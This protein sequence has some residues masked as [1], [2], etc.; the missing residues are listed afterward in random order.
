ME[1]V[2]NMALKFEP[3][4]DLVNAYLNRPSPGQIASEG[5][6]QAL[7]SYVHQKVYE[8]QLRTQATGELGNLFKAGGPYLVGKIGGQTARIAGLDP[9]VFNEPTTPSAVP[10]PSSPIPTAGVSSSPSVS[11]I[12]Q[13]HA[14]ATGWNPTGIPLDQLSQMGDYGKEQMQNY[15]TMGD[16]AMQPVEMKNKE[17]S[18]RAANARFATPAQ[19]AAITSGDPGQI[20][21]SYGGSAPIEAYNQAAQKQMEVK[22]TV[23]GEVSKEGDNTTRI[24]QL[25]GLYNDLAGA[26][27]QN[28]PSLGGDITSKAYTVTGGRIGNAAG[29]NIQNVSAPLTAALNYELTKRF[30]E[31]EANF[32]MDSLM[33]KP[34]DTPVFAQQ[35]LG[36]LNQMI[37]ALETGNDQNIKNVAGAIKGEGLPS[38]TPQSAQSGEVTRQTKDGR[39]AVFD[40][41]TKQFKRYL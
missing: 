21:D 12:V 6:N 13:A 28:K 4:T 35:K 27:S 9:N 19:G 39:K 15:K 3:P 25:R 38:A 36:R 8:Q 18:I 40:S 30:N 14:M 1:G 11:P 37:S 22:K 33:P 10:S 41:A 2:T 16:L 24:S 29:A 5:I 26:V 17:A 32:L 31:Q 23:A 7:Q 20:S 34:K